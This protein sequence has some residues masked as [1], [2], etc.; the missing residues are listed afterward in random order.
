MDQGKEQT[1][2]PTGKPGKSARKEPGR[3]DVDGAERKKPFQVLE[4][5][6]SLAAEIFM[7]SAG[8]EKPYRYSICRMVNELS[9]EAIHAA[10]TANGIPIGDPAREEAHKVAIESLERIY[11]LLPVMR[12]CRCIS[13]GQEAEIQKRLSNLRYSYKKWMETDAARAAKASK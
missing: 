12:R 5:C 10:R 4:R 9:C 1:R 11:D 7:A 8:A 2:S 6:Q 13:I 3:K